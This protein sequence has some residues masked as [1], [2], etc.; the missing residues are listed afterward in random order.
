MRPRH[1]CSSV[2]DVTG[3]AVDESPQQ[4]VPAGLTHRLEQFID[5][6]PPIADM[7]T[8]SGPRSRHVEC[9]R[10]CEQPMYSLLSIVPASS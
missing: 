1:F 7:D 4:K 5:V 10:A 3:S 2:M 6:A 9:P 8:L